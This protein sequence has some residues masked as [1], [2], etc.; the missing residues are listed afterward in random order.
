MP[1]NPM[2]SKIHAYLERMS[3]QRN[4]IQNG[5]A[6]QKRGPPEPT[7][8]LDN[9]KRARLAADNT[10]PKIQIP[11]LPPGPNSYSQLFTLTN[12][13]GLT[14]FDVK[15]LPIDMIVNITLAIL[16]RIQQP[17]LDEASNVSKLYSFHSIHGSF[18]FPRAFEHDTTI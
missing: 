1:H 13:V 15:Q 14:S 11:P 16:P 10:P 5:N 7:D 12:D 8:G 4:D 18:V 2:A 9:A 3:Q 6:P 17:S